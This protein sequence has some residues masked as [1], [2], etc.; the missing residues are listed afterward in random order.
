MR[1]LLYEWKDKFNCHRIAA[2]AK[3]RGFL[4]DCC[5]DIKMN[6]VQ[7]KIRRKRGQQNAGNRRNF[8]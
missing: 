5:M 1:R 3:G 6:V 4:T 2:I 7:Y 8:I